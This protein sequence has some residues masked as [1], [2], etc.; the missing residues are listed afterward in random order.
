[1]PNVKTYKTLFDT[2][3]SFDNLLS[4]ARRAQKGKRFKESTASFNMNLERELIQLQRELQQM[5]YKHG[6]YHDFC[7]YEP[8]RIT[9]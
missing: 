9:S 7:V 8:K 5:T 6:A 1:M 4:A 3:T 2:I